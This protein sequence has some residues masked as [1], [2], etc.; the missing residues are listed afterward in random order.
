MQ[1]SKLLIRREEYGNNKG[2]LTGTVEFQGSCGKV[3]LP[4]D[5]E[6]SKQIVDICAEGIVRVSR[7]VANDLTA[8]VINAAPAIAGPAE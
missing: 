6:L 5:E 2:R 8:E 3:E 7:H 4:L 1:L